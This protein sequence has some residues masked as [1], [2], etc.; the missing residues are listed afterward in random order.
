MRDNAG[1]K[2]EKRGE[3]KGKGE[4]RERQRPRDGETEPNKRKKKKK[5]AL[6]SLLNYSNYINTIISKYM[7]KENL[8]KTKENQFWSKVQQ[9]T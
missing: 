6:K 9:S 7:L 1:Q 4:G 2:P 5:T 8:K 3:S